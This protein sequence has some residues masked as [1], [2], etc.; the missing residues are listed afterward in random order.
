MKDLGAAQFSDAFKERNRES[1][2]CSVEREQ[3]VSG[4][5]VTLRWL[6]QRAG[7]GLPWERVKEHVRRKTVTHKQSCHEDVAIP[8]SLMLIYICKDAFLAVLLCY[9]F[10]FFSSLPLH[11]RL[12]VHL[13]YVCIPKVISCSV[14]LGGVIDVPPESHRILFLLLLECSL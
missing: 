9:I 14:F 11:P 2:G 8:G 4:H 3:G 13:M 12:R 7:E 5:G 10:L 1:W 6:Q